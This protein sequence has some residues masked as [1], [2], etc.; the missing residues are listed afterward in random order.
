MKNGL[1]YL[2]LV[3]LSFVATGFIINKMEQSQKVVI[4]TELKVQDSAKKMEATAE[5][6]QATV[7]TMNQILDEVRDMVNSWKY[8]NSSTFMADA[9][10][11]GVDLTSTYDKA[12]AETY[13]RVTSELDKLMA[14]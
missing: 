13:A 1:G 6:A 2:A 11:A 12:F 3:G 14:N 7:D 4:E 10:K 5:Q 8:E 9:A